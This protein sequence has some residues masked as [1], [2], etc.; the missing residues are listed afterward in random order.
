MRHRGGWTDFDMI[1]YYTKLL[2]LDGHITKE[3]LLLEEDK[4]KIEKELEDLRAKYEQLFSV[5]KKL[6]SLAIQKLRR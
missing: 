2:G 1:N 4:T 3:K 6:D 5:M